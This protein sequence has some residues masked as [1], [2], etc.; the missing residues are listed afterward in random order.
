[1]KKLW[2]ALGAGMLLLGG[3]CGRQGKAND[4]DIIQTYVS[5]GEVIIADSLPIGLPV[6]QGC[7]RAVIRKTAMQPVEVVFDAQDADFLYGKILDVSDTANIRISQIIMPDGSGDGPFGREIEYDLPMRG[8]YR[9][10]IGENMMAGEPWGGDF[11]LELYLGTKIPYTVGSNYFVRNDYDAERLPSPVIRTQEQF[12]SVFGGAAVMGVLPTA[13]DFSRQY[14]IAIVE[15]VTD[16]A[17]HFSVRNL[18]EIDGKLVLQYRREER[19]RRSYSV[20]PFLMVV[21]DSMYEGPVEL[22]EI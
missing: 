5:K 19:D 22:V 18:V 6:E 9:L 12:D 8:A 21:V 4:A 1:M 16:H 10:R 13:I 3:A 15:P 2:L 11:Y 14:V 7:G 17:V 20:R